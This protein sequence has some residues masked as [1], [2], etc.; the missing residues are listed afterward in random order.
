VEVRG[1][2]DRALLIRGV[3]EAVEAFGGVGG[4][5]QEPDVIDHDEVRAQDPGDGL[6]DGVVG[7]VPAQQDAEVFEGE[8]GDPQALLDGVLAERLEQEGLPGAR[9]SADDQ[10]LPA[11][12]PLQ[13]A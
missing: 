4:N 5:G 9:G 10:V 8:P 6:G 12:Y 3:D 2:G 1:D 13:G 11:V 7:A